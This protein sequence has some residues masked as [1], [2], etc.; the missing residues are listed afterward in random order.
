[1]PIKQPKSLKFSDTGSS[2]A[3]SLLRSSSLSIKKN[4]FTLR[5]ENYYRNAV[6]KKLDETIYFN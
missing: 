4:L 2:M 5:Q 6:V 3:R 1:M